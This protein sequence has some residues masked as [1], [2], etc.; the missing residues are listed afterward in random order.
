MIVQEVGGVWI[1]GAP[2]QQVEAINFT[3]IGCIQERTR[4]HHDNFG[5]DANVG[6]LGLDILSD[7]AGVGQIT[8][9]NITVGDRRL[10][11]R[12]HALFF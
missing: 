9:H 6:Q 10:E 1:V 2:A 4:F 8:A 7:D 5:S 3:A 11:A 12:Q